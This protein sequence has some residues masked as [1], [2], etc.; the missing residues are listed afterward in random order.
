ME[1]EFEAFLIIFISHLYFAII[2][3]LSLSFR[4]I[5]L[6]RENFQFSSMD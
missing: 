5:D 2:E 6:S 1:I 4:P 3:S